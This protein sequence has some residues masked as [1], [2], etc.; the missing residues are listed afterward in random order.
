M[1]PDVLLKSSFTGVVGIEVRFLWVA[2]WRGV[3]G[4]LSR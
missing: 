3:P 2:E 1:T 4:W